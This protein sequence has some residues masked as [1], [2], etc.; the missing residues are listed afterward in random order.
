MHGRLLL[1]DRLVAALLRLL[2]LY[3]LLE[4]VGRALRGHTIEHAAK[5]LDG[6]GFLGL[7]RPRARALERPRKRGDLPL[8]NSAAAAIVE[9]SEQ[10]LHRTIGDEVDHRFPHAHRGF[11]C[12]E[13]LYQSVEASLL[14]FRIHIAARRRDIVQEAR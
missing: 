1:L 12:V 13:Y 11:P 14:L 4:R 7:A 6:G 9:K 8:I 10:E 5:R 2:K 3:K